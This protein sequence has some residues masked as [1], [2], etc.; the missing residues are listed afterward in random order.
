[1]AWHDIVA[2]HVPTVRNNAVSKLDLP[3]PDLPTTPIFNP[4]AIENEIR[5]KDTQKRV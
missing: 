2:I 4:E 5:L 1:M 3:A